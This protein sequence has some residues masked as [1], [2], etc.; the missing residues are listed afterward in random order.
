MA[1]GAKWESLYSSRVIG[2]VSG[3]N[4]VFSDTKSAVDFVKC[5]VDFV[6]VCYVK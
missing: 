5:A 1:Y 4:I 6:G 3:P 2:P